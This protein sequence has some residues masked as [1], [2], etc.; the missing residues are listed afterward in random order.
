MNN[1][2]A[3]L[4]GYLA[5]LAAGLAA[6]FLF[7]AYQ[8]QMAELW[9]FIVFALTWDLIGGQMGYNSFGNVVFLGVGMYAC[10]L[11]QVGL[12]Y[13]VSLY[14]QARGGG[15]TIFTFDWQQYLEGLAVGLPV[16]AALA[17]VTAAFL[18]SL[19]LGMRGQYFAICTLGLGIA[20]G[21]IANGWEW[22]GA[23]SGMVP[24]N[25]PD[26][27]GNLAR[28][29]YYFAMA[30]AVLTFLV[31]RHLYATHF[32]LAI[33]A[34]RDDE[35]KAESM[36]LRTTRIKVTAWIISAFFLGI[37]GG[38]MGNLKRFIDPVDTAFAGPTFG[39]W[40]VLMAILGGKG[41][42]WGPV[43]G[44]IVFQ[45]FKEVSWTYLLGWQRVAL[46]LLI[47]L[48]VV[49]FPQGI[50]GFLRERFPERFGHRVESDSPVALSRE[51][52][53]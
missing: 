9:L 27:I 51:R 15:A 10:A 47:V 50:M 21:E 8:S 49:F 43:I 11:T 7:P 53:G 34:I 16:G 1:G 29:Y 6:P 37:A 13:D 14:N 31:L 36:G 42:L 32:G 52:A 48:I 2:A 28:F 5:L 38:I 20:A 46:G 19:V 3:R 26:A 4:I 22:I 44:A 30:L 39:V 23:G 12:F 18:G 35:D 45:V 41:T 40:M 25:A 33:N 24:P 17:A